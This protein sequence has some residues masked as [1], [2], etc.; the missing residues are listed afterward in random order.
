[1][2]YL[3]VYLRVYQGGHI[4]RYTLGVTGRAYRE[5]YPRCNREGI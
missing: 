5:V 3:R 2:V 1:M 4:G